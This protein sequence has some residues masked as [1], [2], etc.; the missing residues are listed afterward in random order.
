[1]GLLNWCIG[2]IVFWVEF[3]VVA[4]FCFTVRSTTTEK[5]NIPEFASIKHFHLE[6]LF[7]FLFY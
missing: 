1:M 6:F 4:F 3:F 7:Y 2:N 5:K